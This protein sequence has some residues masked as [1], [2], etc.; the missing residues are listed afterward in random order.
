VRKYFEAKQGIVLRAIFFINSAAF[1]CWLTFFNIYLKEKIGFSTSQIGVL[2]SILPFGTLII[3]PI[4]GMLADKFVRKRVFLVALFISMILINGILLI[5]NYYL[6]ILFLFLFGSFYSPLTP[7]L[8]TIALDYV[9]QTGK[10]SYGEIRLWSSAGWAFSTLVVGYLLRGIDVK[11]VFPITSAFFVVSGIIMLTMYKPLT[12]KRNIATLKF[13]H[14]GKIII[15]SPRL[16]IFIVIILIYGILTAPV[17]LFI[18]LYYN[19][20]GAQSQYVG[21]AFA[22][23]AM[24]ELPFFFYGKRILERFGA[25]RVMIFAMSVTMVRMLLYG[26]TTDPVIAIIIGGLHGITIALFLISVIEQIHVFIPQEW[27]ATGQSFIYIFYFGVGTALGYIWSGFLS[28]LYS[29]QKTMLI[30]GGLIGILIMITVF[31]FYL[32]RNGDKKRLSV[33]HYQ[34]L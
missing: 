8:D 1:G 34:Y 11:F 13:S 15:D 27:R 4:W 22:V 33:A 18:N 29:V 2:S 32:F 7:M 17:M 9:E 5:N 26:I 25:K 31:I 3:L 23:Q 19:E 16:T 28:D 30:M 21:I 24:C 10:D 14:L 6:F 12:V 20:I